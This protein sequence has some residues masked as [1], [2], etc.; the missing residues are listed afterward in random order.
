[1]NKITKKYFGGKEFYK[2]VLTLAI[3]LMFQQLI[4]S[5]VNLVD[6]LMVGQLGD[7]ALGGVASVN[8][9][10]MIATFGTNGLLAACA[11]YLAQFYGAKRQNKMQETFRFSIVTSMLFMGLFFVLALLMPREIVSFFTKDQ[12][13]INLGVNYLKIACFSFLPLSL[14]FCISSSLRAIGET[15]IPLLI[16]ATAVLTNTFLNYCLI[17]G[18]FGFMK[19][20]VVGAA[21][22]TVTARILELIIYLI[23]LYNIDIPFKTRIIDLFKISKDLSLKIALKAAPLALNEI[24]WSSGQATLFKFYSTRGS[25]VMSGYSMASTISDIFFVL[26]GGMAVATTVLVSQ[27]LGANKLQEAKD[28]AYKLYGFSIMLAFAF[29]LMLYGSSYIA[30]HFYN[31]SIE[32]KNVSIEVLRIMGLMF[33]IYM[34]TC[35]SYFI[36]RAG[37]DTKSTLIMDSGFMWLINLPIV[38]FFA[39]YTNINIMLLYIIGQST[40]IIKLFFSFYLVKKE[41]WVVN[42]ALHHEGE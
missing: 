34:A 39:Y 15:K 29:G 18:N 19:L 20:G 4:T 26:F 9:F 25:E 8:R 33:W 38:G 21:Y 11:I 30:P 23:V 41:K 42:L 14:S 5:S 12:D 1:M 40:D 27:N 24:L 35:Q 16:S 7:I 3:P 22:A 32:A 10:Y 17:F 36:L 28:N 2:L 6:N 37:G 31:V 13:I